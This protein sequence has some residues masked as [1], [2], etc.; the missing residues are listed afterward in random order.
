MGRKQDA[1]RKQKKTWDER[2]FDADRKAELERQRAEAEAEAARQKEFEERHKVGLA[3]MKGKEIKEQID[4]TARSLGVSL[5][6]EEVRMP[7]A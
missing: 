5:D 6:D 1:A 2:L 4:K 3:W 7:K